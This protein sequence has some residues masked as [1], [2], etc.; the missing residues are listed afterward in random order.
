MNI[1][2][3]YM[4]KKKLINDKYFA[5][6]KKW[7]IIKKSSILKYFIKRHTSDNKN[8]SEYINNFINKN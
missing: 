7:Q 4:I 8:L 3:I 5:K 1:T 2:Q 6:K